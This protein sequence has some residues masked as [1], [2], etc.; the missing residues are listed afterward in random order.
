MCLPAVPG[1]KRPC[2]W[3]VRKRSSKPGSGKKQS[4][5]GA[6]RQPTGAPKYLVSGLRLLTTAK[7]LETERP[8]SRHHLPRGPE[9]A[10]KKSCRH[11]M[12]PTKG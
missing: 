12:R 8:F 5:R 9:Q 6:S 2:A 4:S 11:V 10:P 3:L 7:R 1:S